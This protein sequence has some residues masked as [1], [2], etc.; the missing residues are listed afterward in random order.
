MWLRSL[1]SKLVIGVSLLV[2]SSGAI[3]SLLVTDRYSR[4]LHEALSS[5]VKHLGDALALQVTDMVLTNDLVGLQKTLDH[6]VRSNPSLSYLFIMKNGEILAHTFAD[7]VPA[8]LLSANEP[9][10]GLVHLQA[11]A[12]TKGEHY[13]DAAT[14][15]FEGKAGILRLGYSEKDYRQQI[16]A[17]R[18]HMALFTLG[19]L[20]LFLAGGL[21]FVRHITGPLTKLARAAERVD[22]GDMDVRVK[23]KG[24]DEVAALARAFRHIPIVWRNRG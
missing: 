16:G 21:L 19:V 9:H 5:Q 6:Q 7:G 4:G 15:I 18:I 3:I 10:A 22:Q 2:I 12:S 13:L 24:Q 17:L 20:L 23:V 11:I 1:K 8:G 14:P